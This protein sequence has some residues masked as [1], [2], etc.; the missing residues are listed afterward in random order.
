MEEVARQLLR[1]LR[2][3]RSQVAFSRRL[4]YSTNVAAKWER[5]VRYPTLGQVLRAAIRLGVDVGAAIDRFH[6]PASAA[7][8]PARPDEVHGW[9]QVLAAQ[10]PRADLAERAGLSRHQVG[11][12]LRGD[13]A[14]RLPESL[15]LVEGA[16]GRVVDLVALLVDVERVPALRERVLRREATARWAT[17]HRWGPAVLAVLDT[18]PAGSSREQAVRWLAERLPLDS[19]EAELDAA[20]AAGAVEE[21]EGLIH[22]PRRESL[23]APAVDLRQIRSHWATVVA[24]RALDPG[25]A[26]V[27]SF[28]AFSVARADL[29]RIQELQ[30]AYFREVRS[31]VAA[32]GPSEVAAVLVVA[33]VG[34]T[35]G[36]TPPR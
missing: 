24:E 26:D 33:T 30:R 10:V 28:N 1:A 31:I 32:S 6:P 23:T 2:G 36:R 17:E 21:D 25:P 9:L 15:A 29:T 19:A 22:L 16:T 8:D 20:I 3:P 13:N 7:F 35:P 5:G 14:G 4:G 12:L 27:I 18:L 11:R 34:F